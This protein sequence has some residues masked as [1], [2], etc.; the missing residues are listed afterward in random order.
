[1]F[2]AV[3]V[4][5]VLCIV[6]VRVIYSVILTSIFRRIGSK[7]DPYCGLVTVAPFAWLLIDLRS[8]SVAICFKK[9]DT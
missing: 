6:H 1:M 4:I 9:L 8:I 5:E 7:L 2:S 3:K